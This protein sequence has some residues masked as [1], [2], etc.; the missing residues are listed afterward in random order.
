MYVLAQSS[1]WWE[2]PRPSAVC[3]NV[4]AETWWKDYGTLKLHMLFAL[5]HA[6]SL[7]YHLTNVMYFMIM[8]S[9]Q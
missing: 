3:D 4:K 7:Q 9:I 2:K 5:Q 1:L 8:M 6:L